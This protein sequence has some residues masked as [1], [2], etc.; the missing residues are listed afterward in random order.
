MAIGSSLLQAKF[1]FRLSLC[2]LT[3]L[4]F[5]NLAFAG[6]GGGWTDPDAEGGAC[7]GSPTVWSSGNKSIAAS[8]CIPATSAN[9]I[10]VNSGSSVGT[11]T[12]LG[13]IGQGITA[14]YSGLLNNGVIQKIIN[15]DG[16]SADPELYSITNNGVIG[17]N[18]SNGISNLGELYTITNNTGGTIST[19]QYGNGA[20][21]TTIN[22][23][24]QIGNSRSSVAIDN[25]NGV[26]VTLNNY[27]TILGKVNLGSVMET[28]ITM[29]GNNA[30]LNGDVTIIPS[31]SMWLTM[32][33]GNSS[34][35][36]SVFTTQGNIGSSAVS[37]NPSD[38][39]NSDALNTFTVNQGSTLNIS[40]GNL[41]YATSFVN[42]GTV[43]VSA[44]DTATIVTPTNY[45]SCGIACVTPTLGSYT[46]SGRLEI[47]INGNSYGKLVVNGPVTF[48]SGASFGLKAGSTV[49][50]STSYNVLSA[51]SIAGTS[52]L[53][54]AS[55]K[56]IQGTTIYGYSLNQAGGN[57]NVVTDSGSASKDPPA[58]NQANS[59]L[60][61]VAATSQPVE[62]RLNWMTGGA[63]KGTTADNRAWITPYTSWGFQGDNS[64]AYGYAQSV[65]GIAL[66]A[67]SR[68]SP[69]FYI[70]AAF[71]FGG[72]KLTGNSAAT[73][74]DFSG[75]NYQA[76]AYYKHLIDP[77]VHLKGYTT[78]GLNHTSTSRFDTEL[79][80]TANAN[81][82]SYYIALNGALEKHLSID[83]DQ[84]FI[85]S[86]TVNYA[87]VKADAYI[88]TL[89]ES[90]NAQH[91][92]ALVFG[93]NAMY[94]YL[95]GPM[96]R[97]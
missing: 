63:Y 62:D 77:T 42:S 37:P 14:P 40:D 22:N 54:G 11:L 80:Q 53:A 69:D 87:G 21:I 83:E 56:L 64:G 55:G 70:G 4:L 43:S 44:G 13:E 96:S 17:S 67:D 15:G 24:G 35:Q 79:L 66:G 52:L 6:G 34:G 32:D 38:L 30:R 48:Q 97:L 91:A 68:I 90:V 50:A 86:I 46:Q 81:F 33:I 2:F 95:F 88:D 92:Q 49:N 71:A 59:I 47:G 16:A 7:T 28:H 61:I 9:S 73:N 31:S 12:N 72:S 75:Q 57:L 51:T 65:S 82:N 58:A 89:K 23:Y 78:L 39:G 29:L 27:G 41:I 18:S 93:G 94:Q 3:L 76:T 85:P 26:L 60:K 5:A 36:T 19:I 84:Q 10:T 20:Y 8:E 74:E 45:S 1:R 25:T